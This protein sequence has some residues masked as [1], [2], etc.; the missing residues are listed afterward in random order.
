MPRTAFSQRGAAQPRSRDPVVP[1]GHGGE[2]ARTSLS[3]YRRGTRTGTGRKGRGAD[4]CKRIEGV[5]LA[6]FEPRGRARVR[7]QPP[8]DRVPAQLHPR[9]ASLL[10]RARRR[11]TCCADRAWP[12]PGPQAVPAWE[13]PARTRVAVRPVQGQEMPEVRV[14]EPTPGE[15]ER[16]VVVCC[17]AHVCARAARLTRRCGPRGASKRVCFCLINNLVV[18]GGAGGRGAPLRRK[19]QFSARAT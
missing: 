8:R 3:G 10:H 18:C 7:P 13:R 6:A 9:A 2:G 15:G 1:R 11:R 4:P 17:R 12:P 16:V 14:G 5:G 19:V